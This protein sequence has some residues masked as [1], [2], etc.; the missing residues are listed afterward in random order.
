MDLELLVD[1]EYQDLYK[2]TQ[3][4]DISNRKW[5]DEAK[6]KQAL[7]PP[8]EGVDVTYHTITG[9]MGEP[10]IKLRIHR[11]TKLQG[12]L[13]VLLYVMGNGFLFM[14]IDEV[15]ISARWMDGWAKEIGCTF[16]VVNHRLPPA[17]RFPGLLEDCYSAYKWVIANAKKLEIDTSRI[18]I[19][20]GGS[21]G[22]LV[23]A[24]MLLAR[25]RAEDQFIFQLIEGAQMDNRGI[26]PSSRR[27][28]DKRTW[29]REV[30]ELSW[31]LYLGGDIE[32][33][34]NPYAVPALVDDFTGFPPAYIAVGDLDLFVDETI[35]YAQKLMRAGIPTELHVLP[36][37]PHA[38][39]FTQDT[40]LSAKAKREY[41][42][43]LK[44]AFGL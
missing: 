28:T 4:I 19:G 21:A 44:R 24:M 30:N 8:I 22:G 25:D 20:G 29:H 11:P 38:F 14:G 15:D 27:V 40:Y 34:K 39:M 23:I 16:I 35:E 7:E 37:A 10:T 13:P 26:T 12:E 33:Q 42:E 1:P 6:K 32:N 17:A 5:V 18:A 41:I 31:S 43:V 36:A 2:N 9:A 3:K